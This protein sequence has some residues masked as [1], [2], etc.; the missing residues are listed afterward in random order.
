MVKYKKHG[1]TP[2]EIEMD[3]FGFICDRDMFINSQN[4]IAEIIYDEYSIAVGFTNKE[5]QRVYLFEMP[6][7][8]NKN[9]HQ[10]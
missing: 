10:S 3:K 1:F 4:Q 7:D 9:S 2:L 8:L 6:I 5:T